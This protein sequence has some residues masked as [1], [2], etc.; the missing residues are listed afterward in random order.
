MV[1]I[2]N[3]RIDALGVGRGGFPAPC[4]EACRELG[5]GVRGPHVLRYAAGG[6]DAEPQ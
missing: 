1:T 4:A 2:D 3:M 5:K 6:R